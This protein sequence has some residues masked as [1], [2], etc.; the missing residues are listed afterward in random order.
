M[1]VHFGFEKLLEEVR[2]CE[3]GSGAVA[4]RQL[5][6]TVERLIFSAAENMESKVNEFVETVIDKVQPGKNLSSYSNTLPKIVL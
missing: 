3:S 4:A 2:Q 1:P 5:E 6:A